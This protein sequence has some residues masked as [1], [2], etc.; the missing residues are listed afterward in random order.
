MMNKNLSSKY[1][2]FL[3]SVFTTDT[4]KVEY[5]IIEWI[6]K[7]IVKKRLIQNKITKKKKKNIAYILNKNDINYDEDLEYAFCKIILEAESDLYMIGNIIHVFK[8]DRLGIS[9]FHLNAKEIEFLQFIHSN[10][11]D[12]F[13]NRIFPLSINIFKDVSPQISIDCNERKQ[14]LII[15]FKVKQCILIAFHRLF[16]MLTLNASI[17]IS[18]Q[19]TLNNQILDSLKLNNNNIVKHLNIKII[20]SCI[21]NK[22]LQLYKLSL[23]NLRREFL[24]IQMTNKLDKSNE[25]NILQCIIE[26]INDIIISIELKLGIKNK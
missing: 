20:H 6:Q 5:I 18:R 1:T 8:D 23:Q 25:M 26:N 15:P 9:S 11:K 22:S 21:F 16:F 12:I 7:G 17:Q 10:S 4:R 3:I 2:E 19:H 13:T 14:D 24:N